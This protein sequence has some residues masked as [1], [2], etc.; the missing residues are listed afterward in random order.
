[1]AQSVEHLTLDFSPGLDLR[2]VSSSPVLGSK[3]GMEPTL[4][5]TIHT[6]VVSSL[7]SCSV[8]F[9]TLD[10]K[11]DKRSEKGSPRTEREK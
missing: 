9:M 8:A 5:M 3:L 2:V 10:H 11:Q 1:M 7:D 6:Q 4:K